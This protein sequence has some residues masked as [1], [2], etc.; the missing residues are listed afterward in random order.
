MSGTSQKY[1]NFVAEPMSDKP[2]TDLAGIGET[3]GGRLIEAGFD[4]AYTVL[5]QYLVLKKDEELFKEW[6]KDTCN[7]SSKQASDCY[8]CL[9]DWC[10]E[11]L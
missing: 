5:G 9:N 7:A 2:V 11:F 6:M 4:K 1:R 8:N 3:L 10:E